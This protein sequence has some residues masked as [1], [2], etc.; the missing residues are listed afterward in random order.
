MRV[1]SVGINIV[2]FLLNVSLV[3]RVT[4]K[5][6]KILFY[7]TKTTQKVLGKISARQCLYF[8]VLCIVYPSKWALRL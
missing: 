1:I 7:H 5:H 8:H 2:I 4:K 3:I 6:K